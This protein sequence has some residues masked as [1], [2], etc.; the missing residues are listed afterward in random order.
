MI[1]Y[2]KNNNFCILKEKKMPIQIKDKN[3]IGNAEE[4]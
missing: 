4:L 2:W 3:G 1:E